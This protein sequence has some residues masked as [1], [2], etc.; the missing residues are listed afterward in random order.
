VSLQDLGSIGELVAAIATVATLVYLAIQ[1]RHNSRALDRSNEF[2][3]ANSIHQVTT[4]FNELNWR[5]AGDGELAEIHARALRG[6][7]LDA[8]ETTRFTAFVNTYVATIENLV[9]QQGLA[10]GYSDLDS[11]SALDLLAPVL[12]QLLETEAGAT[13]WRDVAPHLYVE[14]FRTQLEEAMAKTGTRARTSPP[15]GTGGTGPVDRPGTQER[16]A[17]P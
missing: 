10:L 3:Q 9:A 4:M 11:A 6:E 12:R 17:R 15:A 1:V 16:G 2:A 7:P 14:G 5:L 13:W 8:A